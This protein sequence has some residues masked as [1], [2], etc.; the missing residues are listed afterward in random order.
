MNE[1]LRNL[2]AV[3]IA[4]VVIVAAFGV[5]AAYYAALLCGI[6]QMPLDLPL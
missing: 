4:I 5:F 3:A 1:T 6:S 2:A